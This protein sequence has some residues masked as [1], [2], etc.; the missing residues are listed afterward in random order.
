[1]KICFLIGSV[2]N[3]GGVQRVTSVLASELCKEH[4]IH[5]LC[6]E[7]EF[8]EDRSIYNL[9]KDVHVTIWN[10]S[11]KRSALERAFY[12]FVKD[13]NKKSGR[14][15]KEKTL[16]TLTNAYYP[17]KLREA[18]IGHLNKENYDIVIGVEGYYSLLLGKIADRLTA[19]TIGWQHNSYEAYL[20]NEGRYY[21]NR[22]IL[23][24]KYIPK[25]DEYIVLNH[26]DK[27][28]YLKEKGIESKVIY[29]PRSFKSEEKSD[30][31]SKTFLAAGRFNY[32]KGF[33]LLIESFNLF[34][35]ENTDWNLVI[36]GEGEEKEKMMNLINTYG[37]QERIVIK[38][39]TDNIKRYFLESSALVL[40]SRW[41]GMPMIVLESLEMG[42]PVIAYNITAIE[43]LV[44]NNKEG[45]VVEK[46]DIEEYSNAMKKI[47]ESYELREAMSKNSIEK[48]KEFDIENIIKEWNDLFL[49]C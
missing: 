3:L 19:K 48:S 20:K 5:I 14:F 45:L 44:D 39:F 37:L 2:F 9:S 21:W 15:N 13:N 30:V 34:A 24:E 42:V 35:K 18:I 36:V 12:K 27:K 38:N 25:L 41:E 26:H 33:D 28:M 11:F 1:M 40:S 10:E 49:N 6:M 8:K 22:D 16:D 17:Q 23:F 32:Q 47:S 31:K 4:D 43:P 29:N 46:Y 7:N